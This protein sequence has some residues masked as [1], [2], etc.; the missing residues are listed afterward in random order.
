MIEI[1]GILEYLLEELLG[2]FFILQ[3]ITSVIYI[4][5]G[6][7]I[8]AIIL[9]AFSFITTIVN[10]L[11]LRS[12]FVKIKEAAEIYSTVTVVREGVRRK[13]ESR[14]LAPGDIFVPEGV[15]PCD[16]LIVAG[17]AF[18]NEVSLTGEN[19]PIS[20]TPQLDPNMTK[21]E[22]SNWLHEGT[23]IIET[24]GEVL[25][26]AV[27]TGF[28]TKKGRIFRNILFKEHSQPE[29]FKYAFLFLLEIF[30]YCLVVYL[31]MIPSMIE[32]QIS[33]GLMVLRFFDMVSWAIPPALPICF[34]L[35]YSLSMYRLRQQGIY[36]TEPFKTIVSGKVKIMCFDKTG[37]LTLNSMQLH[38]LVELSPEGA[39]RQILVGEG[40]AY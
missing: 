19:I 27:Y 2:I 14:D 18:V 16:C 30:V 3:Y 11:M 8:F 22:S 6:I 5:E 34:N 35:C 17:E 7:V 23:S 37:T 36:G 39:S 29:F 20:K 10:Y 38:S 25:A 13:V 12:S 9:L 40:I 4:L 24:R 32:G 1:P 26:L 21:L 31:A 15:L 33:S 28:I